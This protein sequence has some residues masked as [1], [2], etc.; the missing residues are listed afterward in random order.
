MNNPRRKWFAAVTLCVAA[1]PNLA[2]AASISG[3]GTWETTLQGR[4][5][6][7]DGVFDAYYDTTLDI[8]WL[9]NANAAGFGAMT[10]A[11][12]NAWAAGLNINGISGWR[13]PTNTPIDGTSY[14]LY[15]S[16]NGTKDA[17]TAATTTDG[18]DGGWRD[19][20]GNPVSEMGHMYYVTLG[21]LGRCDPTLPWCT[22]QT[23]WGLSNS[24]PFSNVQASN[25]W[26]GSAFDSSS[27]WNFI[28]SEGSQYARGQIYNGPYSWAVH[29]G[30][31][32][33]VPVP[34]AVWL[35]GSGL[36]GLLGVARRRC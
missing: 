29:S 8:T 15:R 35:L 22:E 4:D 6:T 33:A 1:V 25:Y 13:L 21:N 11:E 7:G 17:G 36:L 28:F 20:S 18:T 14:T 3:Q 19:G 27:A 30:D 24:G 23:G 32:S 10:W 31:V 12:A 9:A 34:A 26:S 2:A 5:L 16:T